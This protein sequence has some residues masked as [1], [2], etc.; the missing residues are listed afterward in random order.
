[1]FYLLSKEQMIKIDN[2]IIDLRKTISYMENK[3]KPYAGLEKIVN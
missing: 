3:I 2:A 1:M